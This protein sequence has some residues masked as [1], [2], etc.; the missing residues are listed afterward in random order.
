MALG[1]QAWSGFWDSVQYTRG[2]CFSFFLRH[3]FSLTLLLA[4]LPFPLPF[5]LLAFRALCLRPDSSIL[6]SFVLIACAGLS[7]LLTP[8]YII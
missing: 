5:L 2:L 7:S 8:L 4:F 1:G 6:S 3:F